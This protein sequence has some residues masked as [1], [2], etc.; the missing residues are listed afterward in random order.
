MG[1]GV[2]GLGSRK[3]GKKLRGGGG[4]GRAAAGLVTCQNASGILAR[5]FW[6]LRAWAKL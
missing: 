3:V 4:G 6:V 1:F 5:F 2:W